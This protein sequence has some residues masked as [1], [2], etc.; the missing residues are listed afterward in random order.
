MLTRNWGWVALRG[1]VAIIFGLLT[2]ANPA[3]SLAALILLFGA[4][5]IVDGIFTIVAAIA[6]RRAEPHWVALLLSGLVSIAIGVITFVMPGITATALLF[7]IAAWA[8]VV[9]IAE[10]VAAIRLRKIITGEWLLVL[11]GLLS[12]VFGVLLI[13]N[14]GAGALAVVMWIGA[15]AVV[16]GILLV[17][18]AFRLR[19][20]QHEPGARTAAR[21]V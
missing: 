15:Y 8:I 18:L 3:I 10:I 14:P 20:W 12:V 7:L 17:V 16:I 11:I 6:N 5:A 19:K 9:G 2:L 21:T 1:V 13:T 4:Y